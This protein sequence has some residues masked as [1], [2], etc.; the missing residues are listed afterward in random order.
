[1][2]PPRGMGFGRMRYLDEENFVRPTITRAMLFRILSYFSP[3]WKQI[4]IVFLAVTATSVLG[5]VPPLLLKNI[6][7]QALPQKDLALLLKLALASFGVTVASGLISVGESF[8]NSWITNHIIYDLKNQLYQH[9]EYMSLHF[10]ST[11]KPGE[12][13]T[14]LTSDAEGIRSV[15]HGTIV[16]ILQNVLILVSTAL[17]LLS[18]NWRLALVGMFVIPSF[19]FPTRR[20]GKVRWRIAKETQQKATELNELIQETLSISGS[21]LIKIFT[22]EK[23]AYDNFARVN[24][25][26][27]ALHIKESLAGRWFHM[28]IQIFTT[29]GPLIIYFYGGYLFIKDEI[30][31][32]AIIAFVTMLNRLYGPVSRLSNIHIDITRSLALFERIFDY[33]DKKHEIT[34]APDAFPLPP[35]KGRVEFKNVSFA[36]NDRQETL[37]NVSFTVEPGQMVALV[38][39]SGAGKTTITNLIPRLYDVTAG[40]ILIDGIDLRAVTLASL[41]SQIGIVLQDPYIFN[42]TI[43]QNLLFAKPDATEDELVAACQ[44]A[45]LHDFIMTL[46]DGY[47]T[48]VGNRGIKLSGGEKQRLSLAQ[49]ILKEPRIIILDEATS[50]LDSVSEGLIQKALE[51]L[52]KTRTSFVIAHRLSTIIAADLILVI[53]HGEVVEAGKHE[54]LLQANKLYKVLYDKQFKSGQKV[55]YDVAGGENIG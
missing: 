52:L 53:N 30:T 26:V 14:R 33:L 4:L 32:G 40:Q 24:K 9:L 35:I 16:S 48:M 46:P 18:M 6:V 25:E 38:G 27:T 37:K 34:D 41:R 13:I 22:K 3:Y 47:D 19:V 54:E 21:T 11:V 29:I 51:P 36:Y 17:A 12:I 20:V 49:M 44:A 1:M 45:Y 2:M 8:L 5:L 7:D 42:G 50:A 15:F 39:P 23:T 28:V 10:F 55:Q 31:I 43:R